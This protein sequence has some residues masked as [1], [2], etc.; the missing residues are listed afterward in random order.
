MWRVPAFGVRVEPALRV[1]I[2]MGRNVRQADNHAGRAE[3]P[4]WGI[5]R[6]KNLVVLA[7]SGAG[8]Y[9]AEPPTVSPPISKVGWP[10][11][12]GTH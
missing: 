10:T 6:G 11:P 7:L 3:W 5:W 1:T 12:T 8:H 4:F 2:I 9:A